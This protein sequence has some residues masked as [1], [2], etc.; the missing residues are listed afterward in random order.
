MPSLIHCELNI[1]SETIVSMGQ[2]AVV[3]SVVPLK[4]HKGKRSSLV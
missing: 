3:I 1:K 2:A 4:S